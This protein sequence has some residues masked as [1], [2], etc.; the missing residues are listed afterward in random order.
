MSWIDGSDRCDGS[1]VMGERTHSNIRCELR[2]INSAE[3]LTGWEGNPIPGFYG[4]DIP[5]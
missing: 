5:K 3:R 1:A 2:K 4:T